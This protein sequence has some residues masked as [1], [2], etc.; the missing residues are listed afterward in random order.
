MKFINIKKLAFT[1]ASIAILAASPTMAFAGDYSSQP[2]DIATYRVKL[3][4]L[5]NSGVNGFATIKQ[6]GNQYTV[7][8]QA[9]GLEPNQMHLQHIHGLVDGSNSACPTMAQNIDGDATISLAEGLTTYG[10]IIQS[11]DPIDTTGADGK[12]SYNQTFTIDQSD[13]AKNVTPLANRE[14]VLHGL[15]VAANADLSNPAAG[16]DVTLPVACGHIYPVTNGEYENSHNQGQPQEDKKS[17]ENKDNESKNHQDYSTMNNDQ[18]RSRNRG[19]W[20]SE[21][22]KDWEKHDQNEHADSNHKDDHNWHGKS[23]HRDF[24]AELSNWDSHNSRH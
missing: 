16:Y 13:P 5:N 14:I 24:R 22:H 17:D 18:E 23:G 8:L 9:W 21:D 11:L 1:A 15:T 2:S 20:R 10:P 6:T 4:A 3:D 7:D 12:K 19:D